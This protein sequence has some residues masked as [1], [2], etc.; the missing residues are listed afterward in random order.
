M[1]RQYFLS[2]VDAVHWVA[3]HG[4][5]LLPD[6]RFEVSSGLWKHRDA[7]KSAPM[8]LRDITYDDAG[9]QY[10]DHRQQF[11]VAELASFIDE[12]D[13]ILACATAEPLAPPETTDDFEE[14]RWFPH[15]SES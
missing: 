12:A 9:I 6:Y 4:A 2:F 7:P 3:A 15:P 14:L 13:T 10:E 5:A 1:L 8:S 11:K